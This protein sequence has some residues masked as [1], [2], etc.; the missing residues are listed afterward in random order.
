MVPAPAVASMALAPTLTGEALLWHVMGATSHTCWLTRDDDVIVVT[1]DHA[2]RLPNSVLVPAGSA[3]SSVRLGNEVMVG[4]GGLAG[5]GARWRIVRWW[6]PK[7]APIQTE[8]ARLAGRISAAEAP[9]ASERLSQ[10]LCARDPRAAVR[11]ARALI[12]RG[13]GLTP[14]GDDLLG[15]IVAGY[16]WTATCL[17]DRRAGVALDQTQND[18]LAAAR[19]GTTRLSYTLL[20]HAYCGE[21]AGPVAALL[22]SLAGRGDVTTAMRTTSAI[23]HSSGRAMACGIVAGAAAAS[24]GMS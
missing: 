19:A 16:R 7:P 15:G 3:A 10:A 20:R 24:R 1:A 18:I 17:G 12:G 2:A 21:V 8:R 5:A 4:E 11:A 6:D 9:T 22:R 13:P 14:E 23:G